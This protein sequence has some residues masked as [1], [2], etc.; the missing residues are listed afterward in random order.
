MHIHL[1][2]ALLWACLFHAVPANTLTF[3]RSNF[4]KATT[5]ATSEPASVTRTCLARKNVL[6]ECVHDCPDTFD[7]WMQLCYEVRRGVEIPICISRVRPQHG[8]VEI[9]TSTAAIPIGTLEARVEAES[10][11]LDRLRRDR[12]PSFM[13]PH[14]LPPQRLDLVVSSTST[15]PMPT[16]TSDICLKTEQALKPHL[17]RDR[18]Q[19]CRLR[20]QC[21][22]AVTHISQEQDCALPDPDLFA[23]VAIDTI[24]EFGEYNI[25]LLHDWCERVLNEDEFKCENMKV[26]K[27]V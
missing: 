20:A 16:C 22:R 8:V 6:Q 18:E 17:R 13:P 12:V 3:V 19:E 25:T 26:G 23:R 14:E 4:P 5:T 7:R 24:E 2:I 10:A 9:S 27:D 15:A 21:Q 1:V 11:L